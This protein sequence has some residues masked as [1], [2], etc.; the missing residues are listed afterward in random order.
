MARGAQSLRRE[1]EPKTIKDNVREAAPE[2][3]ASF[4]D[5][6]KHGQWKWGSLTPVSQLTATAERMR[7]NGIFMSETVRNKR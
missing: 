1:R 3:R 4:G 6:P 5:G 2:L 7:V